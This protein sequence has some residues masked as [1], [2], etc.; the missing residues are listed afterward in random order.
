MVAH[1]PKGDGGPPK[2]FKGEHVKLGLKFRVWA[3][4]SNVTKLCHAMCRETG[5]FKLALFLGKASPLEFWEGKRRLKFSAIS[6]N[7]RV[8]SRISLQ[9][10]HISKIGKKLDQLQPSHVGRKKDCELW[11]TNKKVIDLH[12][13]P[14][15]LNFSTDYI[16]ALRGCWP[17]KF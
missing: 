9:Q 14:P 4:G 16:S 8:S 15:K 10:I 7:F 13:D 1:I 3:S 5:V 2:K 12:V 11:S 6:D 17:L